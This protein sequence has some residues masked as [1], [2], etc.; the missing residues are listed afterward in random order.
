M[1]IL[2][3]ETDKTIVVRELSHPP[4]ALSQVAGEEF[5]EST[6][7]PFEPDPDAEYIHTHLDETQAD[8]PAPASAEKST[9]METITVIPET[10]GSGEVTTE[11]VLTPEDENVRREW[12]GECTAI[13]WNRCNKIRQIVVLDVIN[14]QFERKNLELDCLVQPVLCLKNGWTANR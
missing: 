4:I 2:Q 13:D 12:G 5:L 1:E 7:R 10:V 14:N 8:S 11:E 6:E 3:N 9:A